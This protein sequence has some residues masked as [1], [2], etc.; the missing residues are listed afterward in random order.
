M[1]LIASDAHT[2]LVAMLEGYDWPAILVTADYRILAA[3][4]R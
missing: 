3:N 4:H 1:D 2:A